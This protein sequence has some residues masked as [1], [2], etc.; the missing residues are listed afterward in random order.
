MRFVERGPYHCTDKDAVRI[1]DGEVWDFVECVLRY[2]AIDL[3][4]YE[5]NTERLVR[6]RV[7][8]EFCR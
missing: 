8:S 2:N 5:R 3:R 4:Y 6:Y 7:Y 1:R